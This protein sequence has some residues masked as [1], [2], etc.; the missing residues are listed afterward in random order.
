MVELQQTGEMA[1]RQ[2]FA[3][4]VFNT[5]WYAR[6]SLNADWDVRFHTGIGIDPVSAQMVNF[7]EKSGVSLGN[8]HRDPVR[9]PGLYMIHLEGAERSFSYWRDTA[10][11]R[12]L[13]ADIALVER[14]MGAADV[15][16]L[17]GITLAIVGEDGDGLIA[18]MGAARAAGKLVAFDPNIRPRLWPD[19]EIMRV[20]LMAAAGASSVVLPSFDDEKQAFSDASPAETLARYRGAG[21][22][23]VVVK[24]G[25]EAVLLEGEEIPI[26]PV[27]DAVDTTGAGD[28]F[29]GAYL[30]ALASGAASKEAVLRACATSAEVIRHHGALIG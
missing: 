24:N 25:A 30:A 1:W 20:R 26:A 9:M 11:A 27:K 19:P 3:G 12:R 23:S 2:G 29:N 4:D 5:L 7:I 14:E 6:R 22:A 13:A 28:S 18:A 8:S 17:S 21:A 16:Y 10:A 15:I